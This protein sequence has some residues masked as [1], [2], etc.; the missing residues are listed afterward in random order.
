[1]RPP[2]PMKAMKATSAMEQSCTLSRVFD[3]L[4]D[5]EHARTALLSAGFEPDSV[6]L[7][8]NHDEAGPVEGNFVCGNIKE[9]T[10]KR[11]EFSRRNGFLRDNAYEHNFARTADRGNC[12]LVVQTRDEAERRRAL[13]I[14]AHHG[15]RDVEALL[16][17][18]R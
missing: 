17:G 11:T 13:D 4:A 8:A 5:A 16:D 3:R 18:R 9:A 14:M 2:Q 12:L 7:S 15:A 10:L 6:N 1:M